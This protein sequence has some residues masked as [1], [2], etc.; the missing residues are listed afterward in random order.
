MTANGSVPAIS[1]PI[2]WFF[3]GIVRGYFRRTFHGVR[4][5]G[6]ERFS[7]VQGPLI[8]YANHSSWWDP[9]VSILLADR[10][11][12]ERS[13]YAPMEARALAKYAILSKVGLF[14]VELESARGA[15]QFLKNAIAIR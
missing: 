4:V 15:V 8:V 13:H 11:M 2:L 3:R 5:R 9:M 6:A 12:P 10:L 7:S 14:G 1:T